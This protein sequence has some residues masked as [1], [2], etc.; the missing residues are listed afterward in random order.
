MKSHS[1][2]ACKREWNYSWRKYR[3]HAYVILEYGWVCSEYVHTHPTA[4]WQTSRRIVRLLITWSKQSIFKNSAFR[5]CVISISL[6][7]DRARDAAE[8]Y[9]TDSVEV[10][11]T[12]QCSDILSPKIF[13]RSKILVSKCLK[14]GNWNEKKYLQLFV[15]IET[16]RLLQVSQIE[17]AKIISISISVSNIVFP[18]YRRN[19]YLSLKQYIHGV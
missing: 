14:N 17:F 10:L 7:L 12:A 11:Q 16:R 18:T 8:K 6:L 5:P 2:V 1:R 4:R 13:Y 15:T 9:S 19:Y 3:D